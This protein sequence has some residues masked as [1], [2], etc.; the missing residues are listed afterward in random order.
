MAPTSPLFAVATA[1]RPLPTFARSCH[2]RFG[3]Q[4]EGVM[5]VART[6]P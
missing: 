3:G 2:V 1:N 6:P 5:N 4:A